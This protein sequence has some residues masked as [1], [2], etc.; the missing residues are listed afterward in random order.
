[1]VSSTKIL[2]LVVERKQPPP[3]ICSEDCDVESNFSNPIVELL[4]D[5]SRKK[6]RSTY[7]T[8]MSIF[9]L[10]KF[11]LCTPYFDSE[12]FVSGGSNTSVMDVKAKALNW[13]EHYPKSK[14]SMFD[15]QSY[16]AGEQRGE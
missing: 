9:R 14:H 16:I 15:V 10:C 4:D 7:R 5:R 13:G 11:K 1:M 8:G 12:Q 3:K 6:K 2:C